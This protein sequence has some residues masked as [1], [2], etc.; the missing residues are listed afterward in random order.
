LPYEKF[1]AAGC[2]IPLT[3]NQGAPREHRMFVAKQKARSVITSASIQT[4]D[5]TEVWK[6]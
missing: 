5:T 1:Y 2:L 4:K 6:N 3:G